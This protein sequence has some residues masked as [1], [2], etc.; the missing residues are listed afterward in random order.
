ML[1]LLFAL[2]LAANGLLFAYQQGHLSAWVGES[3]EPARMTRQMNADQ[4]KLVTANANANVSAGGKAAANG[5][6]AGTPAAASESYPEQ[7]MAAANAKTDVKADIKPDAKA[8]MKPDPKADLKADPK[9]DPAKRPEI[10]ACTEVGNFVEADAKRFEAQLAPL[11][12]GPRL[13][14]RAIQE[15]GGYMV[16]IPPQGSKEGADRKVQELRRRNVTDFFVI[17][18][19][20][21][22]HWAISLGIFKTE[23]A[24]KARLAQLNQQDVRSA[25]IG[26]HTTTRIAFQLRGLDAPGKERVEKIKAGF[27]QQAI[28][29][30]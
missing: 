25:R 11:A 5:N 1:K 9:A 12:L 13:S 17:Q 24:A 18:E 14:R 16:F 20:S 21:N 19:N 4:V 3:R 22:L 27:P 23:D 28:R 6:G 15:N 26:P 29:G 8:D 7:M 2:L 10:A 30:C